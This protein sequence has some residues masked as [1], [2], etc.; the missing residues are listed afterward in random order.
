MTSATVDGDA[1]NYT[2]W[3]TTY[4]GMKAAASGWSAA[5]GFGSLNVDKLNAY[6]TA[7]PSVFP[8]K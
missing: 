8:A 2:G 5:T 3:S 6:I 4:P 7:N 1:V